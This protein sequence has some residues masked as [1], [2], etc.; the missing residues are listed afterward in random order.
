MPKPGEWW[1]FIECKRGEHLEH[2][3][4]KDF[5]APFQI[6]GGQTIFYYQRLA[7]WAMCGCLV[8]AS[9]PA[10]VRRGMGAALRNRS[11]GRSS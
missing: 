1:R 11:D 4:I 8:R 6:V 3:G 10:M 9:A 5:W 7:K 2:D